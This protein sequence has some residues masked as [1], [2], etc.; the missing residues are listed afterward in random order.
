MMVK[1][2]TDRFPHLYN[3][4]FYN[5]QVVFEKKDIGEFKIVDNGTDNDYKWAGKYEKKD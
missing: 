1:E 4:S 2:F 3:V 5:S